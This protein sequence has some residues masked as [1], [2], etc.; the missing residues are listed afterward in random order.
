MIKG[1]LRA[2]LGVLRLVYMNPIKH[3]GK[4]TKARYRQNAARERE[5][6][7]AAAK[8]HYF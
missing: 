1:V 7:A 6:G 4:L 8:Q 3:T 5:N 2:F